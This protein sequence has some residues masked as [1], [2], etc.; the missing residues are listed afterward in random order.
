VVVG[1]GANAIPA[2]AR[3]HD[4]GTDAPGS[5]WPAAINCKKAKM[6][7]GASLGSATPNRQGVWG[8]SVTSSLDT[9]QAGG[10]PLTETGAVTK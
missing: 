5:F 7:V 10:E 1:C 9:V 8:A 6:A 3:G 4:D 2:P